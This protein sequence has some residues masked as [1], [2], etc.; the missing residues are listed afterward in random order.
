MERELRVRCRIISIVHT[1]IGD[2]Y[3]RNVVPTISSDSGE[4]VSSLDW[5][6]MDDAGEVTPSQELLLLR[7]ASQTLPNSEVEIVD[8]DDG[9]V[10]DDIATAAEIESSAAVAAT[11]ASSSSARSRP[12][13][14][15]KKQVQ[16]THWKNCTSSPRNSTKEQTEIHLHIPEH[17]LQIYISS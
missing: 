4:E 2:C 14:N 11:S 12:P 15:K 17:R 6:C 5:I 13:P 10:Q 16:A 8:V 7:A 9:D 1:A 3:W